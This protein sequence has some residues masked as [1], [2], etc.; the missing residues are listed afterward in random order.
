MHAKEYIQKRL[1]WLMLIVYVFAILKPFAPIAKDFLAHSFD[2]TH[3][4]A[5]VHF[6]NGKY[7][8]HKEM[9]ADTSAEHQKKTAAENFSSEELLAS[10]LHSGAYFFKA[11]TS[12]TSLI[13]TMINTCIPDIFTGTSTPPPKS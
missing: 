9:I 3:H 12:E 1:T 4:M 7:H 8:V 10:H 6:E 11:W 5:T 13:H 2:K